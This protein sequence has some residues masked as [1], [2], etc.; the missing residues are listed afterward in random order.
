MTTAKQI[1]KKHAMLLKMS[2]KQPI[3]KEVDE[4]IAHP[5]FAFIWE[6][7]IEYAKVYHEEQSKS[8]NLE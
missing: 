5:E 4:A 6:A 3:E 8:D 7:M 1:F 2:G